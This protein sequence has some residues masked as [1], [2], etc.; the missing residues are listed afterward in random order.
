MLVT[1]AQFQPGYAGLQHIPGVDATSIGTAAA[2]PPFQQPQ[3]LQP[4]LAAVPAQLLAAAQGPAPAVGS[5]AGTGT[6]PDVIVQANAEATAPLRAKAEAITGGKDGTPGGSRRGRSRP[7]SANTASAGD[8]VVPQSPANGNGGGAQKRVSA[9]AVSKRQQRSRLSAEAAEVGDVG[10][11]SRSPQE[12]L[13]LSQEGRPPTSS[14]AQ[15]SHQPQRASERQRRSPASTAGAASN[16]A[17][18]AAQS[19]PPLQV[20]RSAAAAQKQ[21]AEE[22]RKQAASARPQQHSGTAPTQQQQAQNAQ[23]AQAA[24]MAAQMPAAQFPGAGFG[25]L[26]P[27]LPNGT[28]FRPQQAQQQQQQFAAYQQQLLQQQLAQQQQQQVK[29]SLLDHDALARMSA[30]VTVAFAI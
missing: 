17:Q 27:A 19:L 7:G 21:Q 29:A 28:A 8:G 10:A 25:G 18:A 20:G 4:Q 2:Q 30:A 9:R 11:D 3:Q 1:A 13:K 23:Q 6:M 24:A 16:E 26:A 5:P 14:A 22:E 15:Q 12:T